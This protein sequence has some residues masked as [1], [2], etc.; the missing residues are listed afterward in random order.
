MAIKV[1]T[2]LDHNTVV[3]NDTSPTLGGPL[4]TNGFS[5]GN[6]S[7]PVQ[8]AGNK[9]PVSIGTVGQVLTNDGSGN[10]YWSTVSGGGGTITLTGDV[11]GSGTSNIST[12]ITPTGV[13]AGTYGSTSV[14]GVFTVNAKGQLTSAI[15]APIAITPSQAGLGNVTN[16]LQVINAGGAPSIQESVGVPAL[17]ASTGAIYIDQNVTNGNSIYRYDGSTWNVIATKPNLYSEKVNG[18]VAPVAQA[19]D[20][21]AI[22]SGAETAPSAPGSLA[23]G[24]QSLARIQGGVVQASGRFT[25]NGDAQAGRYML[26]GTTINSAPQE[27]FV[28]GTN[29]N[30]RLTLPDNSTWTFKVTV[31]GHRT[32]LGDGHA[33]YTAAGVI[34]RGSGANNTFIQG[35]V[36]KSVL[37]ESNPVWDINI[38][39]DSINGSL[40]VTVTGESGKTIRWVALVETVEITN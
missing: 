38:A 36:Q 7:N 29:G 25:N 21:V 1:S 2:L 10:L 28:N 13:T 19:L 12:T 4:D 15:N 33:G 23:I 27:L 31:T 9:Y 20:S 35:S 26:R 6:G 11:T 24:L 17:P 30:V 22:G 3:E 14:V 39:A 34:Y 40:K 8:V 18:F 5:I 16:S 37:A 32:D